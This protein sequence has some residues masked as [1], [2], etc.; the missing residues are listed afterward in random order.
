[1]RIYLLACL[2]LLG[3]L[4]LSSC[5]E[6]V[7]EEDGFVEEADDEEPEPPKERVCI[8]IFCLY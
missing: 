7:D 6:D 8:L 5:Q 3:G 2:L 4:Q 1:M